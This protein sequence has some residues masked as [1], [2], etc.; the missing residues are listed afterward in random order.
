MQRR[1]RQAAVHL[2]ALAGCVGLLLFVQ[3]LGV[4]LLCFCGSCALSEAIGVGVAHAQ[5]HPCCRQA[6]ERDER[7]AR[8]HT[9]VSAAHRCCDG[10]HDLT[11]VDA[12]LR[13]RDPLRA[14][15]LAP[16]LLPVTFLVPDIAPGSPALV[17]SRRS[18]APPLPPGLPLYLQQSALL[19]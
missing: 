12:N 8:Q 5:E 18:R 13:D 9:T 10:A 1:T 11:R 7:E 14:Q 15:D 2:R 3:A 6:R 16:L 19:I 4:N 17:A